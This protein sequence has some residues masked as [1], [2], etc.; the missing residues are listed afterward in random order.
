[1]KNLFIVLVWA[2]GANEGN[3]MDFVGEFPVLAFNQDEA[4]MEVLD[5]IRKEDD[6]L[7][8]GTIKTMF[9]GVVY[10]PRDT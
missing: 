4:I 1:M 9:K 8:F 5:R 10:E 7:L 6:E 2:R 3:E